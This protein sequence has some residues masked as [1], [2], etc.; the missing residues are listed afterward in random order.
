MN[1]TE[2]LGGGRA[3]LCYK[4]PPKDFGMGVLV[5]LNG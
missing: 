1:G 2:E 5:L 3:L 4:R